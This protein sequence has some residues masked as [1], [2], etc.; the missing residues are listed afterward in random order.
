MQI[1]ITTDDKK[2]YLFSEKELERYTKQAQKQGYRD[3]ESKYSREV[4]DIVYFEGERG[5]VCSV[6]GD[7]VDLI[8]DNDS[9][10]CV[11]AAEVEFDKEAS[12]FSKMMCDLMCGGIEDE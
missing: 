7:M 10:M 5:V 6:N 3:S 12:D 2:Y 1:Y 9:L 11:P 8:M 4:G